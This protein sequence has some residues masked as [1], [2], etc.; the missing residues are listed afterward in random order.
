MQFRQALQD[1]IKQC[2]DAD[3]EQKIIITKDLFFSSTYWNRIDPPV[4]VEILELLKNIFEVDNCLF[5]LAIDYEV[6]VKGLEPKFGKLTDKNEREFRL[7]FDK[8]IQL[9]F[10][11]PVA[12]YDVSRFL[13][14]SLENV[15][16]IDKRFDADITL[17]DKISDLALL[18]VGTNPKS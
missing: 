7:F 14:S 13:M 17:K 6:V 18:S 11:M 2:L 16:Y 4:A 10:S 12:N 9:P 15:G 3:K 8:I 1:A 5:I